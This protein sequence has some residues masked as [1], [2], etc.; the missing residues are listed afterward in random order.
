MSFSLNRHA[1]ATGD[2]L[3]YDASMRRTFEIY[4][5]WLKTHPE[6]TAHAVDPHTVYKYEGDFYGLLNMLDIAPE[7][8]WLVLRINDLTN[9]MDFP[10]DI[11]EI[12]VPDYRV[13]SRILQRHRA[14]IKKRRE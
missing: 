13:I 9:P 11:G 4:L 8:H 3:F 2:S 1:H 10:Q 12:L 14:I 6:T 7:L 5:G